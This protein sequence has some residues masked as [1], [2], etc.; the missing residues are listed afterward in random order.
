MADEVKMYSAR[1]FVGLAGPDSEGFRQEVLVKKGVGQVVGIENR[2]KTAQVEIQIPNLEYNIKGWINTDT[3][4][5]RIAEEQYENGNAP[6]QWR[7]EQQRK[8]KDDKGNPIPK[9]TPIYELLGKDE[10]GHGGR[11]DLA[12]N[13]SRKLLVGVGK[14]DGEMFFSQELTDPAED[15][16]Y[17]AGRPSSARVNKTPTASPQ[18]AGAV[19]GTAMAG[20]SNDVETAFVAVNADGYANPGSYGVQAP[21]DLYFWLKG[22]ESDGTAPELGEKRTQTLASALL[23]AAGEIQQDLYEGNT[24]VDREVA[25]FKLIV[26]T[27]QKT[28]DTLVPLTENDI[29]N[30]QSVQE[31]VD[32]VSNRAENIVKWGLHDVSVALDIKPRF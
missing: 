19:G 31:W 6:V 2:G 3:E 28:V 15:P 12:K 4:A 14:P 21:I 8:A 7:L 23:G 16:Q 10:N 9:E 25:S 22:K 17:G 13:N 20:P 26:E 30:R 24:T 18:T 29:V 32:S 1:P 11:M 27:I 5:F